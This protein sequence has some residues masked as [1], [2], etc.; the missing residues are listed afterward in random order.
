MIR[1]GTSLSLLVRGTVWKSLEVASPPAK[2]PSSGDLRVTTTFPICAFS[3]FNYFRSFEIGESCSNNQ[4]LQICMGGRHAHSPLEV[5]FFFFG[6]YFEREES[7][8]SWYILHSIE[9]K[10]N[11]MMISCILLHS[12]GTH[13]VAVNL[14]VGSKKL[15]QQLTAS[16]GIWSWSILIKM[17]DRYLPRATREPKEICR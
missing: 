12:K 9:Y 2:I 6:K 8:V 5:F 1:L 15:C 14:S 16:H 17:Y 11:N 13:E 4:R 10:I 3:C 7:K